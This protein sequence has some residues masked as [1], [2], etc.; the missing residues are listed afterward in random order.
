MDAVESSNG[1][2]KDQS[3]VGSIFIGVLFAAVVTKILDLSTSSATAGVGKAQLVVAAVLTIASWVGYHNSLNRISYKIYFFNLPL[4]RFAIEMSHVYLYWLVATSAEQ[5]KKDSPS[6]LPEAVLLTVVF[7]S[8]I[9]WDQVALAMRKSHSYA[10]LKMSEDKPRRRNVTVTFFAVF[11]VL[12]VPAA[13]VRSDGFVV[14]LDS[15][16]AILLILHR[17]AQHY[18]TDSTHR[19]PT[20]KSS[21]KTMRAGKLSEAA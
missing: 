15:I 3:A 10:D 1:A 5:V 21:K 9:C 7:G 16:F 12:I 13:F 11:A 6:A 14:A 8:Y 20:G 18:V 19:N 4:A 17:A 2:V